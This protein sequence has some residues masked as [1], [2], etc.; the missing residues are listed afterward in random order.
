M[1]LTLQDLRD[2]LHG[3]M[4]AD[5]AIFWFGL[6]WNSGP[7]SDL[8]K[9]MCQTKFDPSLY[10]LRRKTGSTELLTPANDPDIVYAH[11]LLREKYERAFGPLREYPLRSIKFDD[12]KEDDVVIC[13]PGR[14]F[15]C[16]EADWPCRVFLK[17][18]WL[19]VPCAE[20]HTTRSFHPFKPNRLGN[21]LGFRR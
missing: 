6:F 7:E 4:R 10:V 13:G 21:I 8:Y 5:E 15:P 18:G 16:I 19:G 20:D 1:A 3:Q 14:Q 17:D 2:T 11:V 12:I 9:A